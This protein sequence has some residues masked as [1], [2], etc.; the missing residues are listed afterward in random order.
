PEK[1]LIVGGYSNGA[2]L[3]LNYTLDAINDASLPVPDRLVLLSPAVVITP[4]AQVTS[5]HQLLSWMPYFEKFK[6]LDILPEYD[7]YK[8]N[9]FPKNA[10]FQN[11]TLT[12]KVQEKLDQLQSSGDMSLFPPVIAFQSIVDATV[13]TSALFDD[14]YERFEPGN[15]ELVLFDINRSHELSAFIKESPDLLQSKFDDTA[16]LAYQLTGVS[17]ITPHSKYMLARSR[18][19]GGTITSTCELDLE[20]PREVFSLSHTAIPFRP[21]D[22]IYGNAPDSKAALSNISPRGERGVLRVSLSLFARLRHNPFFS[23]LDWRLR[24]FINQGRNVMPLCPINE[25]SDDLPAS[26]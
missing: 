9:S 24:R 6:W 3:S 22:P 16:V 26:L 10:A 12:R 8:Y 17:N 5:W 13:K 11:F 1:P 2:A 18:D 21:D 14:L 20:W 23:Y 25:G 19:A 7:P 4:L 15:S